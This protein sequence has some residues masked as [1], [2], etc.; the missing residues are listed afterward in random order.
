MS[1]CNPMTPAEADNRIILSRRTLG[2]YIRGIQET[3]VYPVNDL[4]LVRAE[5]LLLE[6]I[7]AEHP[8]KALKLIELV[9]WW[10]AFEANV[11]GKLN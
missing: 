9:T 1:C 2:A 4:V 3:G 7:A 8:A 10:K 11:R 5:I 6:S